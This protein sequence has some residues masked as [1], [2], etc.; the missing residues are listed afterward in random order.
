MYPAVTVFCYVTTSEQKT[1]RPKIALSQPVK[2]T[3]RSRAVLED[4]YQRDP[5]LIVA[6]PAIVVDYARN[7][8]IPRLMRHIH[9]PSVN[10]IHDE[11]STESMRRVR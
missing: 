11:L 8:A 9:P 2:A 4:L 3:K 6:K 10:K 1:G 5:T 7:P